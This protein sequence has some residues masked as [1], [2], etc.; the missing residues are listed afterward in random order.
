M[1]NHR[2]F[3]PTKLI[4][5]GIFKIFNAV[6]IAHHRCKISNCIRRY[7]I[8]P[9]LVIGNTKPLKNAAIII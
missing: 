3:A 6:A 5:L 7:A 4:G 8:K 1:G 9:Q 2:G